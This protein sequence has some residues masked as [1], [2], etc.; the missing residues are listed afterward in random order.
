MGRRIRV[1]VKTA[2]V[3]AALPG[4]STG[5]V[6]ESTA[7]N[8]SDRAAFPLKRT[9]VGL[10]VKDQNGPLRTISVI[11]DLTSNPLITSESTEAG[12]IK[13]IGVGPQAQGPPSVCRNSL[14]FPNPL[15]EGLHAWI[16]HTESMASNQAG[17]TPPFGFVTST[18]VEEF[19]HS[20]LDFGELNQLFTECA[21]INAHGSG[22]GICKC[23]L[24]D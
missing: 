3:F 21:F 10:G 12:V 8:R 18:S 14:A 15:A 7:P 1:R 20:A 23:G 5:A 13:I 6:E 17:F 24:G 11:A 4:E 22:H 16:N 2:P 9:P 19:A